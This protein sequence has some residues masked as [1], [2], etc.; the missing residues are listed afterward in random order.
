MAELVGAAEKLD[1]IVGVIGSERGFHGAVVL[2]AKGKDVRP[3]A[4][5]V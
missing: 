3:H 2:I 4:K 1:A 5:R